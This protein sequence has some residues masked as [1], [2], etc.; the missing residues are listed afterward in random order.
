VADAFKDWREHVP[1]KPGGVG[2]STLFQ[3]PRLLLGLNGLEP[4]AEQ[5]VHTHDG[6]DKFYYVLEGRGVFTVGAQVREAGEGEVVWAPSTVEHGVRNAGA[7]LLV[8]LVGIAP[9]P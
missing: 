1:S 5:T 6:Q 2:K 9:A 8:L 4:G 3:S 7:R